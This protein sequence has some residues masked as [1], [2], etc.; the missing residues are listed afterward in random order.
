MSLLSLHFK[1]PTCLNR[2]LSPILPSVSISGR[3]FKP[4]GLDYQ[5][6]KDTAG[7]QH[8]LQGELRIE[9]TTV[10]IPRRSTAKS[11]IKDREERTL[12]NAN[13]NQFGFH[14]N[15]TSPCQPTIRT[16]R[17]FHHIQHPQ[18][19]IPASATIMH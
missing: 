8:S 7:N 6:S 5:T 15:T 18:R 17:A 4:E 16:Y 13:Y 12:R 2:T 3:L 11:I 10:Y 9:K 19:G 14:S 1:Q